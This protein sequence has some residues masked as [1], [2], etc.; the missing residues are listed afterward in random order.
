MDVLIVVGDQD[1]YHATED[2]IVSS[3]IWLADILTEEGL[4]GLFVVQARRAEI[5]V[6]QGRGDVTAALRRH[7]IGLHGRDVHPVVPEI[8]E[9]LGWADGVEALRAAEGA[10]LELVGRVFDVAPVC[11]SQHRNYWA[12][13]LH[14]VARRL[15]LPYLFGP[16]CAPPLNSL[17]WYAGALNVPFNA[18]V[19]DFLGFFPAVFDDALGDDAAF[20]TLLARLDAHVARCLD[21]GLPLLV[22]FTCHP[23]RL[24]YHGPL[25]VYRY[26]N[27]RNRG[28][29]A[30]PAGVEVRHARTEVERALANFRRLVRHLRDAP[31]LTPTTV[32][33]VARRYGQQAPRIH[34]DDLVE[35]AS[36]A[37]AHHEIPLGGSLS[38]AEALL[39]FADSLLGWAE[40]GE[41]PSSVTR[42]DL[43]GP[44]ESPPLAPEVPHLTIG[45]V[46]DL[47]RELRALVQVGGHL[48]SQVV[49][50]GRTF[51]LGVLY[52]M[53][54]TAYLA[55]P[56]MGYVVLSADGVVPLS[57]WPRYP[58][59]ATALGEWQQRG[60]EDPLVRPGL[61]ADTAALHARLQTWTL[62]AASRLESS[63]VSRG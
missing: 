17:S 22:V 62:K 44:L 50:D 40:S 41:V 19:P 3:P 53:M 21:A 60:V 46:V 45:Q 1:S 38:P 26:G 34:R 28:A 47:A 58:S 18:P 36:A 56:E 33:E 13:Q 61:S 54:A 11:S 32:R 51:G 30:V 2:E 7:E 5:L 35:V 8:V 49:R 12:P 16:P 42:H 10:E 15:G 31:G 6:E 29:E 39:G 57:A 48:P 27:G 55:A 23:E 4:T 37:V 63:E 52:G 43:L 20:A 59:F 9:G 24:C 14:G 25:E